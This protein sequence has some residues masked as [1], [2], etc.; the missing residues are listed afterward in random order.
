M[1]ISGLN[2]VHKITA[3]GVGAYRMSRSFTTRNRLLSLMSD[4]KPEVLGRLA[5]NLES[6]LEL[7]GLPAVAIGRQGRS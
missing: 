2:R 5:D 4:R 3:A 7:L 1:T 6:R